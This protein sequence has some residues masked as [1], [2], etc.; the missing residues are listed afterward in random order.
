[1]I[2]GLQDI[3]EELQGSPKKLP[4]IGYQPNSSWRDHLPKYESQLTKLDQETRGCTVWGWQNA[5]EIF[6]KGVYGIEPNY[7][8]RFTYN[9]VPINPNKGG[10]PSAVLQTI[11]EDGLVDDKDLPMTRTIGEFTDT[12]DITGSIRAKGQNWLVRNEIMGE[13]LWNQN[14]RPQNYKEI[15]RENLKRCP[16]PISVSAWN[17]KDGVYVS[18]AGSVNNHFCVAFEMSD[19]GEYKDCTVAFDSYD[20]SI[21]LLHPNHNIRT[22]FA[23]WINKRTR[24]ASRRHIR[25]LESIL[26]TLK[27]MK[28]TFLDICEAHLGVDV[29]PDDR[30]PDEVACAITIT[31]LLNKVYP[32]VTLIDGTWTLYDYMRKPTSN[33]IQLKEPE[34][35]CIAIAPTGT[36]KK[37]TVGHVWVG[38]FTKNYTYEVAKKKYTVEQ[39]MQLYFFK[40][41]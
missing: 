22:A 11:I 14:N 29:T 16:V 10:N 33:F 40:H 8:E 17:Y 32:F 21:K 15:L 24:T 5:I 37:G 3:V 20:H 13:Q 6:E 34:A 19:Y 39:G 4:F 41:V 23:F 9:L 27:L 2:Y 26:K 36:G 35:G 25:V 31:T 18:D 1:M 7:S 12:S 38:K 30:V 28:P